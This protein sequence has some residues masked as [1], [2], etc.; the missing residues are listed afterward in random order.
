MQ[1]QTQGRNR[2]HGCSDTAETR[3][4]QAAKHSLIALTRRRPRLL[5]KSE[6]GTGMAQ[7]G[8]VGKAAA[9]QAV[10]EAKKGDGDH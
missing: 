4:I 10:Q 3:C 8:K 5:R 2:F 6:G 1:I 7:Q 9:D